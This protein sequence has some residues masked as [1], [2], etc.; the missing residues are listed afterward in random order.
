MMHKQVGHLLATVGADDAA[1]LLGVNK[2]TLYRWAREGTVPA[3]RL[4]GSVRFR[5]A[6][7]V[8]WM[9]AQ[10]RRAVGDA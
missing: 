5:V 6:T 4:G 10:E 9:E 7:L 1:R 3:I 2:H 8:E